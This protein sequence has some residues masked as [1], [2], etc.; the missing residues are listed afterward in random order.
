MYASG[1]V[2]DIIVEIVTKATYLAQMMLRDTWPGG[3]DGA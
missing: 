3:A 1:A 2:N